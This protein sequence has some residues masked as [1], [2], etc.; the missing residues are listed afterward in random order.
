MRFL[1]GKHAHDFAGRDRKS[2]EPVGDGLQCGLEGSLGG[3]HHLVAGGEVE[4][5]VAAQAGESSGQRGG[6]EYALSKLGDL[7]VDASDLLLTDG[8]QPGRLDLRGR[9]RVREG[10]VSLV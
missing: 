9:V 2:A 3:P 6:A 4:A 8:V 10:G 7:R 5:L 1:V